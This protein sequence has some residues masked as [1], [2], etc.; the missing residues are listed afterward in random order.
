MFK[1][2]TVMNYHVVDCSKIVTK[3]VPTKHNRLVPHAGGSHRD[4][5]RNHFPFFWVHGKLKKNPWG[6]NKNYAKK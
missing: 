4:D 5:T 1:F 6:P 2:N 3:Y